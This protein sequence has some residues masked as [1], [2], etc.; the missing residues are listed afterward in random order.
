MTMDFPVGEDVD[1]TTIK[2]GMKVNFTPI[3]GSG[4]A[5]TVDNFEGSCQAV[6][7][8]C[9]QSTAASSGSVTMGDETTT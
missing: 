1:L 6:N 3:K 9:L 8:I 5:W 7:A 2:P 4:G